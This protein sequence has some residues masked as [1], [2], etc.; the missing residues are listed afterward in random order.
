MARG[1]G[2]PVGKEGGKV[3]QQVTSGASIARVGLP[4]PSVRQ[5]PLLAG[6]GA[7]TAEEW[8]QVARAGAALT[9]IGADALDKANQQA[10]AGYLAAQELEIDRKRIDMQDQFNLDPV[11]FDNAWSAYSEGKVSEAETWALP[12]LKKLLGNQGNAAYA[13]LLNERRGRDLQLDRDRMSALITMSHDDV[14]GSAMSGML[15]TEIGQ[16]K[17]D[18]YKSVLD[19]AVNSEMMSKEEADR[20]FLETTNRA[21][22]EVIIKTI[23]DTY[24]ANREKGIDA[25]PI[26]LQQAEDMLLRSAD[27]GLSEEQRY[28]YFSKAKSEIGALEAERKQDLAMAREA[29]REAQASMTAGVR[30]SGDAIDSLTEQLQAAGGYADAARLRAGAIRF[31]AL[32]D[33]AKLPLRDQVNQFQRVSNNLDPQRRADLS[34]SISGAAEILGVDPVDLATAI[35]YE[36]A[37]TFST[38]IMG[39]KGGLYQ[40]LIQFSPENRARYGIT[41]GMDIEAQMAAVTQ[42]LKDRGVT[43]GMGLLDIYAAINAGRAG[44]PDLYDASDRPGETVRSHVLR[45]EREHR[46]NAVAIFADMEVD[47]K[48]VQG[49]R[50]LLQGEAKEEWTKI[51]KQ[52]DEGVRPDPES[53]NIVFKAASLAGD[54]DTLEEIADRMDRFEA[55]G[56]VGQAPLGA[57]EGA[58]SELESQ[59]SLTPGQAAFLRETRATLKATEAALAEDPITLASNRFPERFEALGPLDLTNPDA[60]AQGLQ[61]RATR[62]D[63]VAQNYGKPDVSILSAADKTTLASAI[64]SPFSVKAD[65]AQAAMAA[66]GREEPRGPRPDELAFQFLSAIPD[67]NLVPSLAQPEI[68]SALS[69]ALKTNDPVKFTAAMTF[70]DQLWT[71]APEE[72]KNILGADAVDMLQD[73]QAKLRY[74]GPEEL[75]AEIKQRQDPAAQAKRREFEQKGQGLA[76]AKDIGTLVDELDPSFFVSGPGAPVDPRTRD[77]ALADYTTLFSQRYA[78]SLDETLAHQQ[79]IEKM[80]LYWGRSDVNQGRLTLYAP[81]SVYKPVDGSHDWMTEQLQ[82]DLSLRYGE[83]E[84]YTIIADRTTEADVSARKAPSYL[85]AVKGPNGYEVAMDASNRPLRYR[86][87][88]PET[89]VNAKED[90]A[91]Q[92]ARIIEGA[93]IGDNIVPGL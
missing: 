79:A 18:K 57:Q 12:H 14:L 26:A 93:R 24:Q 40:G 48:L 91:R 9:A 38:D 69:G 85:I 35:S 58:I 31:D 21:G 63:F 55:Q 17:I 2:Y 80:R 64:A 36:T 74:F 41:K 33:F 11:G 50:T 42:Y 89:A 72:V 34:S 92:R 19:A 65:Q 49:E 15:G 39:G 59:P 60:L 67:Q 51:Q 5:A 78:V 44:R 10:E 30:V 88:Q 16:A 32:S 76:K 87:E 27:I 43:P 90:F 22:A 61:E 53:L 56:V 20:K 86:W 83:V 7:S 29:A 47:P 4:Q 70:M 54:Q 73:W 46:G 77:A 37:G 52:L 62:A 13:S 28:G 6:G 75:M 8:N 45:M 84:D 68:K 1:T 25:G 81:E 3:I 71:R 23:G 82:A 66:A